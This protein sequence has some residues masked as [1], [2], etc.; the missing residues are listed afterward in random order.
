[1]TIRLHRR[2]IADPEI[3]GGK[4]IVENTRLSVAHILGLLS[5]DMSVDEVV[6]AYPI[7]AREDVLNVIGYAANALENDIYLEVS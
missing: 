7:L 6:E 2:I 3:L 4:P 1:M 5:N